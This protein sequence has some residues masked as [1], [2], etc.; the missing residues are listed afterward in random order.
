MNLNANISRSQISFSFSNVTETISENIHVQP[1][2]LVE[3]IYD[4]Q[5]NWDNKI[6]FITG[7]VKKCALET[8]QYFL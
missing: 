7:A 6:T 8:V 5:R 4:Q 1:L 2:Q 3:E